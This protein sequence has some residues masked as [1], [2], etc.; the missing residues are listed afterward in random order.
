MTARPHQGIMMPIRTTLT[1]S[2]DLLR[3]ARKRAADAHRPLK[4]VINEALRIG[5]GRPGG[6]PPPRERYRVR[7][8]KGRPG[9]Q[10]GVNLNSNSDLMD[11]MEGR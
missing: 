8:F 1:L 4:D 5:L 6:P 11:L 7:V 2:D 9:I 10:P 3:L